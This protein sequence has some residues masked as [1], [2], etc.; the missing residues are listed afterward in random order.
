MSEN[1]RKF[2]IHPKKTCRRGILPQ[3]HKILS[4]I[5]PNYLAF[6]VSLPIGCPAFGMS[7]EYTGLRLADVQGTAAISERVIA[8]LRNA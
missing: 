7:F 2:Y 6:E 1:A 5:I 3:W 4:F 8:N